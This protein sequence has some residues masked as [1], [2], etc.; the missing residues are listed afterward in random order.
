MLAAATLYGQNSPVR[1][2][3]GNGDLPNDPGVRGGDAGAGKAFANGLTTANL[4]FFNLGLSKFVDVETVSEGLGPRFNLDSC[5]GCHIH[6]AVG[7]SSPPRNNPQV[8]RA[9][10]MAP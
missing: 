1:S 5:A 7:G 2:P 8:S 4:S 9:A 6:P 3:G 10:A